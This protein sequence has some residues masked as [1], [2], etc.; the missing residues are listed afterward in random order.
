VP[1]GPVKVSQQMKS[2][3]ETENSNV[4]KG[5]HCRSRLIHSPISARLMTSPSREKVRPSAS[6]A[7]PEMALRRSLL[8]VSYLERSL[9]APKLQIGMLEFVSVMV[10][11]T[12]VP[13]GAVGVGI[14]NRPD[15]MDCGQPRPE[16]LNNV[17]L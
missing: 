2:L 8:N 7:R 5:Q 11:N 3:P 9:I 10:S 1:S 6:S 4:R 14:Y 16:L 17:T 13:R 12:V 15:W